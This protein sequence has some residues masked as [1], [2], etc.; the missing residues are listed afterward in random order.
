M[1]H[2]TD[3]TFNDLSPIN[4]AGIKPILTSRAVREPTESSEAPSTIIKSSEPVPKQVKLI[5]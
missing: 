4:E 5:A 1:R 2:S 3:V